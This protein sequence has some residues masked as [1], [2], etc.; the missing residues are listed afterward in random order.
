MGSQPCGSRGASPATATKPQ[1]A[2][3]SKRQLMRDSM[4]TSR[5]RVQASPTAAAPLPTTPSAL[6]AAQEIAR[7]PGAGE[8]SSGSSTSGG[9]DE[10]V[11]ARARTLQAQ[12]SKRRLTAHLEEAMETELSTGK[13]FLERNAVGKAARKNYERMMQRLEMYCRAHRLPLGS[14]E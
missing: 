14:N 10:N 7:Q 9:S 6:Q 3:T 2:A 11:A 8:A 4:W 12:R 13:T 5:L 1:S